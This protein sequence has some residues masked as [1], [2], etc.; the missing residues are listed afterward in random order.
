[1]TSD[2]SM[3]NTAAANMAKRM[4][5]TMTMINKISTVTMTKSTAPAAI[6]PLFRWERAGVRVREFIPFSL[7][8]RD[9]VRVHSMKGLGF[10]V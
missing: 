5:I 7:W 1:M 6:S 2:D 3:R 4:T 10:D 9:R 8:E